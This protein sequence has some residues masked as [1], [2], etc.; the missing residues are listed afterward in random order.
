M[1]EI[2]NRVNGGKCIK[3]WRPQFEINEEMLFVG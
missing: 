1:E 2:E 3:N